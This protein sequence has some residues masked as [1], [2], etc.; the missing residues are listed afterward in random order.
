[1]IPLKVNTKFLEMGN[2]IWVIIIYI[3]WTSSL[4]SNIFEIVVI[5]YNKMFYFLIKL[6]LSLFKFFLKQLTFLI[7]YTE[8]HIFLRISIYTLRSIFN[9]KLGI[10]T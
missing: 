5:G 7:S 3:I 10:G 9:N 2:T 8:T 4:K 6:S 1:M